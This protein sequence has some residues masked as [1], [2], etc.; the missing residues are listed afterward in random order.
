MVLG[1]HDGESYSLLE[2]SEDVSLELARVRRPPIH[3]AIEDAHTQLD[4]LAQ[5]VVHCSEAISDM[6]LMVRKMKT[7]ALHHI[8][9]SSLCSRYSLGVLALDASRSLVLVHRL[10][11]GTTLGEKGPVLAGQSGPPPERGGRRGDQAH[12]TGRSGRSC[13]RPRIASISSPHWQY[14]VFG[15]KFSPSITVEPGRD[16]SPGGDSGKA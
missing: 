1:M 6:V 13:G 3:K 15:S 8:T 7:R 2:P 12:G 10:G 5:S 4:N 14:R 9:T 16:G 11:G